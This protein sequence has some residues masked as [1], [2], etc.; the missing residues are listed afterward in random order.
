MDE[1]RI[2]T[3]QVN[4]AKSISYLIYADDILIFSKANLKSLKSIKEILDVFFKF[5]GLEINSEKSSVHYSKVVDSYLE[6][7]ILLLR[8]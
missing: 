5:S 7:K 6:L 2:D 8:S 4:G 1:G 3:Y